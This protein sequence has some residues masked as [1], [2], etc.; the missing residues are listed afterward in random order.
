M[1]GRRVFVAAGRHFKIGDDFDWT[2]LSVDQRRVKLL[3]DAGKLMHRDQA[4]AQRPAPEPKAAPAKVE[5]EVVTPAETA[6]PVTAAEPVE[7]AA[8][9][10]Q[11]GLDDLTMNELR[12]IAYKE[13]APSRTSRKDQKAAIREHRAT[14]SG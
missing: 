1:I 4:T 14:T 10:E 13:G 5:A 9:V 2:R 11:D 7:Q 3:F 12:K 8:P 6:E